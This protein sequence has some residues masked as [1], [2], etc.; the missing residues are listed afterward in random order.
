MMEQ[1]TINDLKTGMHV[2]LRND[3]EGIVF[4]DTT[5]GDLIVM[6]N[7]MH[8]EFNKWYDGMAH[9]MF[10]ELDIVKVYD[11]D[12][13]HC[14]LMLKSVNNTENDKDS[15]SVVELI[16]AEEEPITRA[17]AEKLLGRKIVD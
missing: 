3:E 10:S 4:R 15:L 5:C 9:T 17:E 13:I 11:I 14:G 16:Y 1:M 12:T 7:G 8:S 6:L 2:V